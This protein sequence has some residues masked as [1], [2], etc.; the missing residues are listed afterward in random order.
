MNMR[1]ITDRGPTIVEKLRH[2]SLLGTLDGSYRYPDG[3]MPMDDVLMTGGQPVALGYCLKAK[4]KFVEFK[5][6]GRW[7][8]VTDDC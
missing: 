2:C 3:P 7:T 1:I 5:D 4:R 6:G 8:Y